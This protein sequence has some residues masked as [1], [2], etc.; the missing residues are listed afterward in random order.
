MSLLSSEN[1]NKRFRHRVQEI[2]LDPSRSRFTVAVKLLVDD[3]L[4]HDLPEIKKNLPLCWS[5]PSLPCDVYEFSSVTVQVTGM[6]GGTESHTYQMAEVLG[7]DS[8]FSSCEGMTYAVKLKFLSEEAADKA[9]TEAFIQAEQMVK[10]NTQHKTSKVKDAFRA[11]LELGSTMA[12]LDPSGGAKVVFAVCTKAWEH[13][14]EQSKL[15]D[16]VQ[17]LIKDLASLTPSLDLVKRF[18]NAILK[19]TVVDMLNLIEDV[20]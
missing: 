11:L 16:D 20:S 7:Q 19:E 6:R 9:Y 17:K 5:G 8:W 2:K 1:R 12:E 4:V 3:E 13:L 10:P 18:A 15:N 14:E